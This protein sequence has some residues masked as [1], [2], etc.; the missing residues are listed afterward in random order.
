[1]FSWRRSSGGECS[2]QEKQLS[3]FER[4][5]E[6]AK[7]GEAEGVTALY[8]HFLPGVFGY[9]AARVPDRST[10]EDL[11][12]EVFLKMVEGIDRVRTHEEAGFAAWLFQVAR[13]TVAGYY[14][15]REKK[16]DCVSLEAINGEGNTDI[17]EQLTSHS[18]TDP[19]L[20]LESRE[21]WDV[22]VCAINS[23]TEEQ[24]QVLVGRLILGYDIK[25][26]ARMIGKQANAVKALQFRALQSL[27]RI[28]KKNKQPEMERTGASPV[29]T[30][31]MLHG[32]EAR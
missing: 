28:L 7:K 21:D 15:Q 22:V 23:L 10:A 16:P 4:M 32:E 19:V 14:Q 20:R 30:R 5:L 11:T 24:R 1:M 3:A 9:I 27:N 31:H 29:P 13:F 12:S 17:L 6:R 18:A 8:R 25:T 2:E 26:V